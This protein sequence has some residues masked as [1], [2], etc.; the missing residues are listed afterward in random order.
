LRTCDKICFPMTH[1]VV[2]L[3]R[4]SKRV[5]VALILFIY[6]MLGLPIPCH[7]SLFILFHIIFS[8][9][10]SS[11]VVNIFWV[12]KSYINM[13]SKPRLWHEKWYKFEKYLGI[14]VHVHMCGMEVNPKHFNVKII[15][16]KVEFWSVL[17]LWDKNVSNKLNPRQY[18]ILKVLKCKNQKWS[19]EVFW[20]FG[21]KM[22]VIN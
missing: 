20:T 19:F 8:K 18:I 22:E 11:L 4:N 1:D 12:V 9:Q 2:Y 7:L 3:S 13:G 17:N 14:H 5:V 15:S 21:T 10:L 6:I 16:K